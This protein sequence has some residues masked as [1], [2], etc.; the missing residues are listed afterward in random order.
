MLSWSAYEASVLLEWTSE[1]RM[2]NQALERTLACPAE[3]PTLM[4]QT[5]NES[6]LAS[7]PKRLLQTFQFCHHMV[8]E[9]VALSL[10]RVHGAI[11]HHSVTS[12]MWNARCATPKLRKHKQATLSM[13]F[14]WLT[15]CPILDFEYCLR[16]KARL[17]MNVTA[18]DLRQKSSPNNDSQARWRP[19]KSKMTDALPSCPS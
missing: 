3:F 8:H 9:A 19:P 2:G 18:A 17:H 7:I 13:V 10:D 5:R 16:S 12:G 11:P 6:S 14:L 15:Q 4:D 1:A